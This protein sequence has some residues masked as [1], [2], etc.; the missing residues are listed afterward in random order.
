MPKLTERTV[1]SFRVDPQKEQI[2]W[3]S[4]LRG[5]ALRISPKG[6]KSYFIQYRKGAATRRMKIGTYGKT[7]AEA[8]RSAA[9]ALL[10]DVEAGKDPSKERHALRNAPTMQDLADEY[11]AQHGPKKRP[12]SMKDDR[13][14]LDRFILPKLGRKKLH[15]ISRQE[16][17]RLHL[18]LKATP[19]QAN[20][21]LALLS[22]MFS[23]AMQWG[24]TKENP[25]R[26]IE[27]FH[28]D[29]RERWLRDDE[30]ARLFDAIRDHPNQ[31]AANAIR[32][33]ILTGSRRGEV[34][35]ATWDQFNLQEGSW[36][37]PSHHTKQKK[38]ER[39]PLSTQAQELLATMREE[40]PEGLYLFPGEA[41]G[42]PL[43][44]IQSFWHRIR[45]AA[46]LEG[47]R[48]HDLRHTYASH[49]VSG[50]MS[51][52]MV[53]RLLG[54]T[55]PGTTARY[56]HLADDPLREATNR[57]GDKMQALADDQ[58]KQAKI[59]HLNQR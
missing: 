37:K 40:D 58:S 27:R 57:L 56:A 31:R 16:L 38:T 18:S 10:G 30:L 15:E 36:T 8:A 46:G 4:D 17:S 22:K 2:V 41:T 42:K 5:F 49:L 20:R 33:M 28:E 6:L 12:S 14:M 51:L 1:A 29:K 43:Q 55:Q 48:L 32:L 9:R 34:L 23:L 21:L 25:V 11:L 52:H 19:Y 35:G 44:G 47:V 13:S 7:K 39:I 24:W 50:G 26:G 53:G 3:D 54:H 45:A 59:V